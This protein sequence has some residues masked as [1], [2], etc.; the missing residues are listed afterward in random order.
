M[1][2]FSVAS[3]QL[4]LQ[5]QQQ[6]QKLHGTTT[7]Y[8][9]ITSTNRYSH[10]LEKDNYN[11]E[12]DA[13][14]C[15]V[16]TENT[17]TRRSK[18]L[19][20]KRKRRVSDDDDDHQTDSIC[21]HSIPL[22]SNTTLFCVC[23][24]S[25]QTKPK[26]SSYIRVRNTPPPMPLVEEIP[27]LDF[28]SEGERGE[29]CECRFLFDPTNLTFGISG[30]FRR[31][32]DFI[33]GTTQPVWNPYTQCTT[34]S[35]NDIGSDISIRYNSSR[36][37][38]MSNQNNHAPT[39]NDDT[40]SLTK[41]VSTRSDGRIVIGVDI[42]KNDEESKNASIAP[43]GEVTDDENVSAVCRG[44]PSEYGPVIGM[45]TTWSVEDAKISSSITLLDDEMD[46]DDDDSVVAVSGEPSECHSEPSSLES[47][48]TLDSGRIR[49]NR[50]FRRTR[51]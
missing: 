33:D 46:V 7:N 17:T 41:S 4:T 24:I 5:Q 1:T 20:P 31:L 44:L 13:S 38:E 40:V 48:L 15:T 28:Y 25:F 3:C 39:A 12:D 45:E 21:N 16:R 26:K 35:S 36:S 14:Y 42:V 30:V 32:A 2:D 43:S 19:R 11:E 8:F 37:G 10:V 23:M 22:V 50:S 29:D 18:V 49:M 9:E 6:Q 27:P 51:H 47:L 34:S